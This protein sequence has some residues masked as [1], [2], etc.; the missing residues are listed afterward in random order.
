MKGMKDYV[1]DSN[2]RNNHGFLEN[3]DLL[4]LKYYLEIGLGAEAVPR[5]TAA[6]AFW[7]QRGCRQK[8]HSAT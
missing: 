2:Q 5:K 7:W 1:L 3:G 4:K 6:L 8:D